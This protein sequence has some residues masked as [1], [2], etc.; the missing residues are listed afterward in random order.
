VTSAVATLTVKLP[1]HIT[2]QPQSLRV[3][4]GSAAAFSVTATGTGPLICQWRFGATTIADA[5]NGTL[6][7]S[8]TTPASAGNYFITITNDAG[9]VTSAPA[10]LV[11]SVRP[12][13]NSMQVVINGQLQ[14]QLSGTPGDAYGIE[15]SSN[16]SDWT[17]AATLTNLMGTIQF[18]DPAAVNQP[19][20]FYRARLLP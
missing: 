15:S 2:A 10:A 14:F 4:E 18:T 7:V 11:V 12:V 1:P 5:T 6:Y 19:Q 3:L 13:M 16:L 8:N 17:S 9:A 20:R